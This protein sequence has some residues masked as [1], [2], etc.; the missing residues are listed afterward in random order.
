MI[1]VLQACVTT[2]WVIIMRHVE[3][4]EERGDRIQRTLSAGDKCLLAAHFA[5]FYPLDCLCLWPFVCAPLSLLNIY[6]VRSS[7][8]FNKTSI[9]LV[10]AGVSASA[11]SVKRLSLSISIPPLSTITANRPVRIISSSPLGRQ[12]SPSHIL[13]G[14]NAEGKVG[15]ATAH[16]RVY[17]AAGL[18]CKITGVFFFF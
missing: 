7:K 5:P 16:T 13:K 10:Q 17:V 8:G 14:L 4:S 12:R 15:A 3:P 11:F 6:V 18:T 9:N 2:L 1:L